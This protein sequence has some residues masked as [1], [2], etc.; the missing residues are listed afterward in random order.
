MILI[1]VAVGHA[2]LLAAFVYA[3]WLEIRAQR[4]KRSES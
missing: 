3:Q 1:L 4:A 2:A